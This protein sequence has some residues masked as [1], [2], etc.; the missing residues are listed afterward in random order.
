MKTIAPCLCNYK[1]CVQV[2]QRQQQY[3]AKVYVLFTIRTV[4]ISAVATKQILV[5]L[6]SFANNKSGLNL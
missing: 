3:I 6:N 2:N 1:N 4:E 5:N